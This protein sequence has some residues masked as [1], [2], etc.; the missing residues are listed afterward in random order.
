[1]FWAFML[2][3][4]LLI[5]VGLI[6][7]GRRFMKAAPKRINS[8][9]GYR[10]VMSMKNR[11]TWEY[12]HNYCGKLW[13]KCGLISLPL[14]ITVMLLVSGKSIAVIGCVGGVLCVFELI[15]LV[16]TVI[17]TENALKKSFDENGN[18]R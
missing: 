12:A 16:C 10:T 14:I 8:L 5:P 7:F 9:F 3:M 15:P 13:Y 11:D 4:D 6:C 1:M 17:P 2:F 18:R